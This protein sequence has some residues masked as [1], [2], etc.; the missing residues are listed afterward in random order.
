MEGCRAEQ[1]QR[2]P[3]RILSGQ[4]SISGQQ[5]IGKPSCTVTRMAFVEKR[6]H[7]SKFNNGWFRQENVV[8]MLKGP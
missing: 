6:D 8:A 5:P 4:S 2:Q 7:S 3:M 1:K